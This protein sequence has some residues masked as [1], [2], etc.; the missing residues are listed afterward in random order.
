M[1]D[2]RVVAKAA[3]DE[4][5]EKRSR[6][7]GAVYPVESEAQARACIEAE[8]KK[9]HDARHHCFCYRLLDGTV[10]YG[11]DGEPQGTAGQPML[12]VYERENVQNVVCIVTRY[13]GGILL[14][15]GGLTRAYSAAAKLA[16]DA[17]GLAEKRVW[18]QVE[19]PCSY[20][21]FERAKLELAAQ[22]GEA[23][24]VDYGERILIH[25][26][27][28]QE[29][30]AAL[31]ERLRELSAGTVALTPVSKTYRAVLIEK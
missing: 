18:D 16:L 25:A 21:F 15:A 24:S 19:I 11:D 5:T 23:E 1:N 4:L 31:A 12:N 28:P 30:T 7:I 10:R 6:F 9:Y 13:F 20:S 8:K 2:Y 26:A 3:R 29:N 14:G 22:G 27:L 17:A